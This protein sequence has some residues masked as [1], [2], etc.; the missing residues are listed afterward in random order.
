MIFTLRDRTCEQ[1]Y[2]WK[3]FIFCPFLL[4]FY[5]FNPSIFQFFILFPV[6]STSG[7]RNLFLPGSYC[8]FWFHFP[9][10]EQVNS[11]KVF[12]FSTFCRCFISFENYSFLQGKILL[13]HLFQPF[14]QFLPLQVEQNYFFRD[15]LNQDL[16]RFLPPG[17]RNLPTLLDSKKSY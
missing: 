13:N 11:N 1:K 16:I 8:S 14:F 9:W 15:S 3:V 12:I 4:L 7:G 2:N 17:G 10:K 5:L 6:S